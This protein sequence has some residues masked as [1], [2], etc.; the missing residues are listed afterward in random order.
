MLEKGLVDSDLLEE[1][2]GDESLSDVLD[3]ALE[4]VSLFLC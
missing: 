1:K 4:H 3:R 2:I